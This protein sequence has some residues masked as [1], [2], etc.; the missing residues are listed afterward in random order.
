MNSGTTQ[1]DSHPINL[2]FS[3][4]IRGVYSTY[5]SIENV[6]NPLDTKVI[7]VTL[8]VVAKHNI[9]RTQTSAPNSTGSGTGH[10]QDVISNRVFDVLV[11]AIDLDKSADT[12][13]MEGLFYGTVYNA[14]SIV[15]CNHESVPLEL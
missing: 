5:I 14:R 12:I 11:N 1:R 6:D 8:E 3:T 2:T 13:E 9:R 7:R 10:S 15:I 4:N